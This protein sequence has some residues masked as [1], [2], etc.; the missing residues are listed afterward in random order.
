M[1]ERG[2][3]SLCGLPNSFIRIMTITFA[4]RIAKKQAIIYKDDVIFQENTNQALC[5]YLES[6]FPVFMVIQIR[7]RTN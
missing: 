6:N 3:H 5:K 4:G 7:C 1:F 2:F